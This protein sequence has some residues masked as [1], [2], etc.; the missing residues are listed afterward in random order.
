MTA[1]L[2]VSLACNLVLL[3]GW[4]LTLGWGETYRVA[5]KKLQERV[6]SLED[7]DPFC[8]CAHHISFHDEAGCHYTVI[9]TRAGTFGPRSVLST[10]RCV[11]YVGPEP[12]PRIIELPI[13]RNEHD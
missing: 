7:P 5:N 9:H 2:W 4:F 12:L 10:C 1:W 3:V 11:Q 13:R 8:G 6:R